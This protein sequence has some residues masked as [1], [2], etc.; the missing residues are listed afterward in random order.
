[1]K[2]SFWGHLI[3]DLQDMKLK[4]KM[5]I[6]FMDIKRKKNS[7]LDFTVESSF[8]KLEEDPLLRKQL[9]SLLPEL[10]QR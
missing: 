2:I 7:Y 9:W 10:E 6:V 4:K 8:I 5:F 3:K 1:M